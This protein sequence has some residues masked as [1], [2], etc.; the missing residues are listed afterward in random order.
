MS[1][2]D[3]DHTRIEFQTNVKKERDP[4]LVRMSGVAVHGNTPFDV[5]FISQIDGNL[6]QGGCQNG[7][8]L[9]HFFKHIV[10]LYPWE[11]YRINHDMN[12]M[13]AVKMYDSLE[14]SME[15]VDAI[16]NWINICV[17]DGPT[18]V[19]C[20][21]GLNRSSLVAAR[22]LM[23]RGDDWDKMYTADEAIALLR[24]RRSP[25]CLCNSA[26]EDHLRNL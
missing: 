2:D 13:L 17:K 9:P 1:R 12:S 7:L 25:A 10:S 15:Q 3:N 4:T 22:S 24:E 20:Q 6:W 19:H 5:P 21:A 11:A 23:L 26:F 16:A 18:L 14:Q 8:Q